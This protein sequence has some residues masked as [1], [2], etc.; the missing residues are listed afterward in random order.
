MCDA[1]V[2]SCHW[3]NGPWKPEPKGAKVNPNNAASATSSPRILQDYN[4]PASMS[5]SRKDSSPW[6]N[7]SMPYSPGASPRSVERRSSQASSRGR[8]PS[9]PRTDDS[10]QYSLQYSDYS[11][12]SSLRMSRRATSQSP[13]NSSR[14]AHTSE[15]PPDMEPLSLLVQATGAQPLD[16]MD[17]LRKVQYPHCMAPMRTRMHVHRSV[18]E[19]CVCCC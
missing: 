6:D 10:T 12:D 3:P 19:G 7:N 9:R 13:L 5:F 14:K 16:G 1:T 2:Q 18:T 17:C 15:P 8:S 4:T 11:P